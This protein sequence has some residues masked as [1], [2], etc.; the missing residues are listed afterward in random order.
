MFV[1]KNAE[2]AFVANSVFVKSLL[3]PV[4]LF[5]FSFHPLSASIAISSDIIALSCWTTIGELPDKRRTMT[6]RPV[7]L[8]SYAPHQQIAGAHGANWKVVTKG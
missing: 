8:T 3:L 5:P 4:L 7:A 2:D 6:R 1:M